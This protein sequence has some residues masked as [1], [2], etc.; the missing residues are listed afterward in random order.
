MIVQFFANTFNYEAKITQTAIG[1]VIP[2]YLT[3]E[4]LATRR[5]NYL[6]PIRVFVVLMFMLFLLLSLAGIDNLRFATGSDDAENNSIKGTGIDRSML[7]RYISPDSFINQHLT[8]ITEWLQNQDLTDDKKAQI[9]Q[10]LTSAEELMA[11]NLDKTGQLTFFTNSYTFKQNDIY[12]LS[13]DEFIEKYQ[14]SSLTDQLIFRALLRFTQDPK[15]FV[16]FLFGNMTWAIFLDVLL[17][18]S[19]FKLFYP[20]T[21]YVVHFVYHLHLRSFIF[22]GLMLYMGLNALVPSGWITGLFP[23]QLIDLHRPQPTAGVSTKQTQNHGLLHSIPAAVYDQLLHRHF[24]G[25]VPQ[26]HHVLITNAK[27]LSCFPMRYQDDLA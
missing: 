6:S 26:F 19:L 3:R 2:G 15:G 17:M 9:Q 4:Y 18:A 16:K 1:L 7:L 21:R 20:K 25:H 8:D 22:L 13:V 23:P 12:Q 14:V 11:L 5:V 27:L 10:H 24:C